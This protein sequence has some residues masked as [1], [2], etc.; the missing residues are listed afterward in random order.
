MAARGRKFEYRIV[1]RYKGKHRTGQLMAQRQLR[2]LRFLRRLATNEP[3]RGATIQTLRKCWMRLSL[4][5][6]VPFDEIQHLRAEEVLTRIQQT[7]PE[8]EFARVEWRQ[9]GAWTEMLDPLVNLQTEAT[10][11]SDR[12]LAAIY[13]QVAEM[14]TEQLNTW[15]LT[16]LV[17]RGMRDLPIQRRYGRKSQS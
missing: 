5:S 17:M 8:V 9:V 10:E 6:D 12:R 1:W 2:I 3:W 15:R 16:P 11:N 14:T 13:A 4:M 7:Y